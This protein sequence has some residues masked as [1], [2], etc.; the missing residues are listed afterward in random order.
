[1]VSR[2][3]Y[4]APYLHAY[5]SQRLLLERIHRFGLKTALGVTPYTATKQL[6]SVV[7]SL[8]ISTISNDRALEQPV[9]LHL[10]EYGRRGIARVESGRETRVA[11]QLE[12]LRSILPGLSI[13][14]D[15]ILS[16][17]PP[18]QN[19]SCTV[20]VLIPVLI[21]KNSLP[22]CVV[23]ML[24]ESHLDERCYGYC[25]VYAGGTVKLHSQS[26]CALF[27][28]PFFGHS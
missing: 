3:C 4:V 19:R 18:W 16:L 28:V 17:T 25:R 20:R 11:V 5:K 12:E 24:A 26:V 8:P 22:D 10:T 7:T 1:M 14:P 6:Y 21:R 15:V 13:T 9:R 2:I 27:L 23:C